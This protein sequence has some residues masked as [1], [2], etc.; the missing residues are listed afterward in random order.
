MNT[1]SKHAEPDDPASGYS[2][3]TWER[4]LEAWLTATA[5][6]EL[7]DPIDEGIRRHPRTVE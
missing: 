7:F 2:R 5:A 1:S 4:E 6:D 3:A